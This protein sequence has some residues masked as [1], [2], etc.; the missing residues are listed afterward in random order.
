[1]KKTYSNPKMRVI[2]LATQQMLAVS[3]VGTNST[4]I[5]DKNDIGARGGWFDEDEE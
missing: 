2:K 4:P 1:M 3:N 5:T